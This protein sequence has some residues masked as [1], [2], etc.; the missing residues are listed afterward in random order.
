[1]TLTIANDFS[2]NTEATANR[3]L[4][5]IAQGDINNSGKLQA[6]NTLTLT[7]RDLTNTAAGELTGNTTRVTTS[8]TLT[9]RGLI[10]G[11]DT[12][13]N[14][15]TLTNIGAGRIYGDTLS[16]SANLLNNDAELVGNA[17]QAATLAARQRLNIAVSTL[18]NSNDASVLSKRP[19][20]T[21]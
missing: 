19:G 8:G 6:G 12:Q 14:A 3:N 10:D 18:N 7:S 11:V 13:I 9:N 16:I 1:M 21:S 15:N 5:I 17:L 20:N 4:N 2:N